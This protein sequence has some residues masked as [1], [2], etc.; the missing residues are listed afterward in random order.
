M[1]RAS[2]RRP[3]LRQADV[4]F[5][6]VGSSPRRCRAA[7]RSRAKPAFVLPGFGHAIP[8]CAKLEVG[9]HQRPVQRG[10]RRMLECC[11]HCVARL[12]TCHVPSNP[13]SC[14]SRPLKLRARARPCLAAAPSHSACT[15]RACRAAQP[16]RAC[17]WSPQYP[18]L[19]RS[20]A[21]SAR[22]ID[23]ARRAIRDECCRAQGTG[24]V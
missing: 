6:P 5:R 11:R 21:S 3:A 15:A 12:E 17:C 9:S 7:P 19:A 18:G 16:H 14:H 2:R 22:C 1:C 13:G 24:A 10:T 8:A 23:R 20:A 4:A